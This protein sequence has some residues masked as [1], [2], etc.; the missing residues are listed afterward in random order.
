MSVSAELQHPSRCRARLLE[1]PNSTCVG[2]GR[3]LSRSIVEETAEKGV[4]DGC[5]GLDAVGTHVRSIEQT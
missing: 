3:G 4:V 5:R 2:T 1:C